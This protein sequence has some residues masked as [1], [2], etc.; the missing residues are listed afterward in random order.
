MT[1]VNV[2]VKYDDSKGVL[3]DAH[4]EVRA[5]LYIGRVFMGWF[6]FI[7]V[8]HMSSQTPP[9]SSSA[10]ATHFTLTRK[11]LDFAVGAGAFIIDVDIAL[12]WVP[13]SSA[14]A[15]KS[16]PPQQTS[17]DSLQGVGGEPRSGGIIATLQSAIDGEGVGEAVE[18]TQATE[19]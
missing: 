1:D 17:M 4:R 5:K 3:L 16:P 9:A 2:S 11:E 12:E 8:F 14:D 7:P 10:A 13:S 6:W 18:V 15:Q 19:Q